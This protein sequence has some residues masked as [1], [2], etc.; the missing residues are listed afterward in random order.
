MKKLLVKLK[1]KVLILAE[2]MISH[3]RIQVWRDQF[4]FDNSSSNEVVGGK[5]WLMWIEDTNLV[6]LA[7]GNQ[8]IS[9]RMLDNLKPIY[10][11]LVYAK[12]YYQ[13]RRRLWNDLEMTNTHNV[14]WIVV[15]DFN[16]IKNDSERHGGRPRNSVASDDFNNYIDI[17]GLL[18]IQFSG[19]SMS[20]CNGHNNFTQSWA[21]V[22]HCFFNTSGCD[23]YPEAHLKYL[24]RMLSNH[25]SMHITLARKVAWAGEVPGSTLSRLAFKLKSLKAAALRRSYT[26]REERDLTASQL[27]LKV[28]LGRE[29]QRLSQQAKQH[30]L[31]KGEANFGFFRVVSRRNRRQVEEMKLA[32]GT[33]LNTPKQV[34]NDA[35][36]YFQ[37]FLE[38]RPIGDMPNLE[39]LV[40]KLVT[41]VDNAELCRVPSQ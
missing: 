8:F 26:Q 16:I 20:W 38:A 1:P 35:L 19:S 32:D 22:D 28:W 6:V 30:W 23:E 21:F 17:S 14:P 41:E 37:N 13:G 39:G 29:E 15:G 40:N 36:A 31:H 34:Y 25:A 4:N 33:T 10:V 2:P 7:M 12:C 5:L 18:E 3:S 9:V 11:T 24:A 27:E